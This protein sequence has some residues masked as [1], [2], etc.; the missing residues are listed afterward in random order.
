MKETQ[1]AREKQ[2]AKRLVRE[3]NREEKRYTTNIGEQ[4]KEMRQNKLDV[5]SEAGRQ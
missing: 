2:R 5:S 1:Q 4:K 3:R